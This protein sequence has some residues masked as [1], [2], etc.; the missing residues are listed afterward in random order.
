MVDGKIVKRG[1]K[2]VAYDVSNIVRSAKESS[3][4]IRKSAGGRLT[5][6]ACCGG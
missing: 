5:P 3:L 6:P 4:R 1:G 2:L